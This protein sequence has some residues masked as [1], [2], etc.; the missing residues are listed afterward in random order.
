M[1]KHFKNFR[2]ESR[3]HYGQYVDDPNTNVSVEDLNAGSFQ[4]MADALELIAEDKKKLLK[5]V[6]YLTNSRKRYIE[7]NKVLKLKN[8]A[9]RGVITKLK[10]KAI[11]N[12]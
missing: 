3:K 11:S 9:L 2:E 8:S 4:R 6:E 1:S 5:E 10:N 12:Q 7:E